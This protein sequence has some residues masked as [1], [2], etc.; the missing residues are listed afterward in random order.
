MTIITAQ[1]LRD[2]ANTSN[3]RL[4]ESLAP[5][6]DLILPA[7][8]FNTPMRL[9]HWLGQAAVETGYWKT[10]EEYS[11][12]EGA[13]Y[14]RFY[15]RGAM[16]LTWDSNYATYGSALGIDLKGQPDLVATPVLGTI[17]GAMFW[18]RNN[19]LLLAD[20]NDAIKISRAINR[21]NA[22][23]TRKA[24]AEQ[25]RVNATN[26]ALQLLGA[27]PEP[28]GD[29]NTVAGQQAALRALNLYAGAIDGK[30]GPATRAAVEEFQRSAGLKVDGVVGS[31]TIAALK[32][33]LIGG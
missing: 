30:F 27:H 24:N 17:V 13:A 23:D 4:T 19:L 25:D 20:Q 5:A 12:G 29:L 14:G 1:L 21:G 3:A 2:I 28:M 33:R 32:Q 18:T 16:Q 7:M 8:G 11:R 15:G 6:F 26:R 9:A 31:R 22:N 10:L